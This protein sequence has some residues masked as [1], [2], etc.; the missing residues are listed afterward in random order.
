MFK[1]FTNGCVRIVNRWLPDPFLFAIILT[2]ITFVSSMIGTGQNPIQ[3]VNARVFDSYIS[4]RSL[5][6]LKQLYFFV[7]KFVLFYSIF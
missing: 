5:K 4:K 2:I 1:K 6:A 3:L 7:K